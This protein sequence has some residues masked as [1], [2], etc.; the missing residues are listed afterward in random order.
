MAENKDLK[1]IITPLD[2]EVFEKLLRS[3][4][5]DKRK[6][7]FLISG[8]KLGFALNYRG[9]IKG[10]RLAHNLKL[11]V[12]SQV[13]LWNKV[14]TE[15]KAGCYAG[16]F[17]EKDLPWED[18]VQSPIGLVP[19][20]KGKKTRLNFH[21]SYPKD[22]ESVN[23]GIPKE[24][25]SVKYPDFSKAVELCILAGVHGKAAKSDMSMAF[26]N[27]PMS[28]KSWKYLVLKARNPLTGKT[29]FF[30]DKC[31]PFGSSISCAIFQAFSDA[32]AFLVEG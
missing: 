14:M 19:K 29:Y 21:L 15:V 20:D 17:E 1:N 28:P 25:R 30:V 23:S 10:K 4:K 18:F 12:G 16:P 13:E 9:K 31:L 22:G 11:R 3:N 27:V 2:V 6:T 8:F 26:R 32:V 7:E 24:L 5:K